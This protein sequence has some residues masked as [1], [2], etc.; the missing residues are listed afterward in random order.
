ML[1]PYWVLLTPRAVEN[2][3]SDDAATMLPSATMVVVALDESVMLPLPSLLIIPKAV[4][5]H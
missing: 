5:Y 3:C 1:P 4:E 2:Q